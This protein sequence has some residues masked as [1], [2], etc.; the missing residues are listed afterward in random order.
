MG[1]ILRSK[2][3]FI[4]VSLVAIF[5]Y[6]LIVGFQGFDMCDEGWVTTGYQQ[7]FSDPLSVKY[8][9]LYYN[10]Q[11]MGGLA[12]VLCG[13]IG[14][15]GFRI[16]AALTITLIAF[17]TFKLLDGMVNRWAILLGLFLSMLCCDYGI[18]VFHHN[19]ATALLGIL[20]VLCLFKGIVNTSKMGMLLAG[21][22]YGWGI[23]ARLPNVTIGLLII[24]V[25]VGGQNSIKEKIQ[26][27]LYALSGFFIAVVVEVLLMKSLGHEQIFLESINDMFSA[28]KDT[29]STHNISSMLQAYLSDYKH[30][31]KVT[32]GLLCP[33]LVLGK[34]MLLRNKLVRNAIN[35]CFVLVAFSLLRGCESI[36]LLYGFCTVALLAS[37]YYSRRD[38]RIVV[39]SLLSL[40]YIY[41]QVLGSDLG[42]R[43][44]GPFCLYWVLP[45]SL[46][47]CLKLLNVRFGNIRRY[48]G[49]LL[50]CLSL[51][52]AGRSAAH[53]MN[54]CYF[55][56]GSRWEK[57]YLIDNPLAT[58]YT[59]KRNSELLSPMLHELAKYVKPDD[60]LLCFQSIP[61]VHFLTHTR[62][63]LYN[64]WVWSYDPSNLK[65]QM[66]VAEKEHD[67]LPVIVRDKSHLP[68]WYKYDENWNNE[69]CPDD[70]VHKKKRV[71][72]INQFIRKHHYTVV[73]ENEVFQILK[74]K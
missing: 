16:M 22:F 31:F 18:L 55:D 60:Y 36:Y 15:L 35:V 3:V 43:N 34:T 41:S 64:P 73:W 2:N 29:D 72:C 46:G 47:I 7:I 37:F 40:I 17:F 71:I 65:K 44:M 9:F 23:F 1:T 63:Y 8:L 53:I 26:L 56:A 62:P 42:V 51:L 48:Y 5:C 70:Y 33:V 38:K 49:G 19:Y 12:N 20:L 28:G 27:F 59:T 58:T 4:S 57:R 68:S 50:I 61:M 30:I 32:V 39:L 67:K 25:F 69:L 66:E 52:Y 14:I 74:V 10:T 45:Y 11:L 54:G 21:A 6:N 24:A 13:G